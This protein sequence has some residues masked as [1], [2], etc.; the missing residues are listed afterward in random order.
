MT[1][2][3][4]HHHLELDLH[5]GWKCTLCGEEMP[6]DEEEEL[7]TRSYS[8]GGHLLHSGITYI[9]ND[10]GRP[11]YVLPS[12]WWYTANPPINAKPIT[13]RQRKQ[14]NALM[15]ASGYR[16]ERKRQLIHNGR[17]P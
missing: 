7:P 15:R 17:K 11:E 14:Y 10:T 5:R 4:H 9:R 16:A 6:I 12:G 8:Q 1:A 13:R 3:E 2:Q